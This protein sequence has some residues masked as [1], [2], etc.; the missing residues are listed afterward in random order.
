MAVYQIPKPILCS[1]GQVGKPFLSFDQFNNVVQK[2]RDEHYAAQ[3]IEN[4][5][6]NI[7]VAYNLWTIDAQSRYFRNLFFAA[8]WKP[9]S[10][11]FCIP[12]ID[13]AASFPLA[14]TIFDEDGVYFTQEQRIA[15]ERRTGDGFTLTS[16]RRIP[17][18]RD[19]VL[20]EH[21]KCRST[22]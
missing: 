15:V 18:I 11:S 21:E 22:R 7:G 10:I 5:A 12:H 8:V 6:D 19:F 1:F 4:F 13:H 2:Y 20:S 17:A 9:I 14:I 3:N 16:W